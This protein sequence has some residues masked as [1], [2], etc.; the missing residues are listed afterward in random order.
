M[1]QETAFFPPDSKTADHAD[2]FQHAVDEILLIKISCG[3]IAA[4]E[5][6]YEHYRRKV[7][8]IAWR[9]LKTESESEDVVQEIFTKIWL[10]REKLT[11]ITQLNSWLNTLIRNH[12]YNCLRK[13]AIEKTFIREKFTSCIHNHNTNPDAVELHELQTLIKQGINNLTSQQKKVFEL[14]RT[15][16]LKHNEIAQTLGISNETVKKHIMHS[17]NRLKNFLLKKGM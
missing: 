14:S 5:Y 13:K 7:F 11:E 1:R 10:H 3:D 15:Q 17:V 8:F 2:V 4:F 12:L 9:I 16:G 6:L